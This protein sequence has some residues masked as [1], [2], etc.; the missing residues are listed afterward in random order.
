[1]RVCDAAMAPPLT[2]PRCEKNL[3]SKLLDRC[4]E[5]LAHYCDTGSAEKGDHEY[6]SI[7]VNMH[8][9]HLCLR[10]RQCCTVCNVQYHVAGGFLLYGFPVSLTL[11][12]ARCHTLSGSLDTY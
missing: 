10:S 2:S 4:A 11:M 7:D 8:Q 5:L 3:F 12:P 1:M 9:T 6:K